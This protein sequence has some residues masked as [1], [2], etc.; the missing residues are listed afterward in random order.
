MSEEK[1]Q[2][3]TSIAKLY[4]IPEEEVKCI[5]CKFYRSASW[6]DRFD[7]ETS[8]INYC[9]GFEVKDEAY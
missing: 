4:N 2:A 7:S 9:G 6:C 3:K 8:V 5:N 1:K